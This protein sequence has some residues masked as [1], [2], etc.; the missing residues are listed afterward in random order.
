M[1]DSYTNP[2]LFSGVSFTDE[3]IQNSYGFVYIITCKVTGR[4]YIGRKYF[5]SKRKIKKKDK[6]RTTTDSDWK[7]YYGSSEEVLMEVEKH[8]KENF[9]REILSLHKTKG[10]VNTSEVKEQFIR[11]VLENGEYF[12]H[13]INGKWHRPPEHIIKAR[14]YPIK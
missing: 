12:N 3:D 14:R 1:G 2:W 11:N 10:D 4:K 13:N 5:Y 7:D 6:R 8:G 9:V